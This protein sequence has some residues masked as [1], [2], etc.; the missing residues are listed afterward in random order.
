MLTRLTRWIAVVD[1]DAVEAQD[2]VVDQQLGGFGRAP[3]G[4]HFDPGAVRARQTQPGR[5]RG[6]EFLVVP[7]A[8]KGPHDHAALDQVTAPRA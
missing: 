8:Q 4:Q 5:H 6:V 1:L 3:F 7:H 2:D